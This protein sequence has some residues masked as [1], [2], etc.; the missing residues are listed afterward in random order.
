MTKPPGEGSSRPPQDDW[1]RTFQLLRFEAHD[2]RHRPR[3]LAGGEGCRGRRAWFR[4]NV[5][6]SRATRLLVVETYQQQRRSD[7][8]WGRISTFALGLEEA[9]G[10]ADADDRELLA[11]L[12][13]TAPT[14][15]QHMRWG[16][17]YT[18]LPTSNVRSFVPALLLPSVLPRLCAS[19]RFVTSAGHPAKGDRR[20]LSWDAGAAWSFRLQIERPADGRVRLVGRL[21]RGGD[22]LPVGEPELLVDGAML[23]RDILAGFTARGLFAWIW[24]LREQGSVT[25]AES[26]LDA[27]LD[28]LWNLPAVPA[29]EMPPEWPLAEE[30]TAPRARLVVRSP[31]FP[32]ASRLAAALFF[33]YGGLEVADGE[34]R[35]R[36]V[37]RPGGRVVRRDGEAEERLAARLLEL[38]AL[39]AADEPTAEPADGGRFEIPRGRLADLV[40][41]LATDGWVVEAEDRKIR[42]PGEA[43][44]AVSSGIEWLE[45]RGGIDFEGVA[46]ALPELLRAVRRRQ[47]L[48]RLDDGSRGILPAE[49][50]ELWGPVARLG[51]EEDGAW[52]L[53][54][55]QA[56][57]LETLLEE[58]AEVATDLDFDRLRERL[59]D[60]DGIEPADPPRGF[61]GELRPYQRQGLGWLLFLRRFRF[62]GCLADDMGLGKTVQLL[63]LLAHRQEGPGEERR[64]TLVVVPRSLVANW[65]EET[66]RFVPGLKALAYRGAGRR[67]WLGSL[68]RYDLVVTTYGTLRRDVD[69]LAEIELDTVVLDEAQAIKNFASQ[70]ARAC[71][72]LRARHRLALTGTPVENHLGELWSLFA[73][74]NPGM[75]GELK[76]FEGFLGKTG[77]GSSELD[78]DALALLA[79]ALRPFVL[80]RTKDQVLDDLPPKSELTLYCDL[81]DRQRRQYDEL[82]AHYQARIA[83]RVEEVGLGGSKIEVIEALLRLRQAACHPGLLDPSRA[84]ERSAKLDV[85]WRHLRDVLA[86]GHKALVFSQ[87]TRFLGLLRRRLDRLGIVYEYLDGQTARRQERVARFQNDDG[88]PLFLISLK[89]GGVGLNLTAADYVFL[90]DPWWNPAVEAQAVD[91]AH[92]IGQQRPVFAYR[93]VTRDTVE[94]KVV[95][96]QDRK[97]R[98]ADAVL[99]ADEGLMSALRLEDL[100][101]LLS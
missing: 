74:L 23:R 89:A 6:E 17:R 63:A 81:R 98:L 79:R 86:E 5:D 54:S 11:L 52:R 99:A 24:Q 21:A 13:S 22:S 19:G 57:F 75:L 39:P 62:G 8:G 47:R 60:F 48:V 28:E 1:R 25:V 29:V 82:R 78:A 87:F 38:G 3:G 37:D 45:L 68:G 83:A 92:R 100:R 70:T 84:W 4:L 26:E 35:Q 12:G 9:G 77:M 73:F 15:R 94:E 96:L 10:F 41:A 43:R 27:M 32:E 80:R 85:L 67:V 40:L 36:L 66:A 93:L 97:R 91:R 101:W 31:P 16:G 56:L 51:K 64:P 20:R 95:A 49:W 14:L 90:L 7:G 42:R 33:D 55:S 59:H 46:L 58:A 18:P 61:V 30:R 76:V 34:A 65:L 44:F 72:R 71:R 88:C 2:A 53:L 69:E 50:L